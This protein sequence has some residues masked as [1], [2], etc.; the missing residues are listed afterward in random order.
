MKLFREIAQYMK[1]FMKENECVFAKVIVSMAGFFLVVLTIAN[2]H[3]CGLFHIGLVEI[4]CRM[5][6]KSH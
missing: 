2:L 4:V 5:L 1:Q 6:L 3:S